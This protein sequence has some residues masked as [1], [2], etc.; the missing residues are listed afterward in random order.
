M[1]HT[2]YSTA[3]IISSLRNKFTYHAPNEDQKVRYGELRGK[4]LDLALLIVDMTPVCADQTVA[5]RKLHETSMAV[6]ATIACNEDNHEIQSNN[7]SSI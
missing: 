7:R 2:D 3:D 4:F 5:L 1:S 6:N